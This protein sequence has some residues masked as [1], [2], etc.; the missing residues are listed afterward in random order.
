MWTS[1]MAL[2][3]YITIK[4]NGSYECASANVIYPVKS[5]TI[6]RKPRPV[7]NS[8]M[9]TARKPIMA[10]RPLSCSENSVKPGT[11]SGPSSK[12]DGRVSR[13]P[14]SPGMLRP[15]SPF[16]RSDD[17]ERLGADARETRLSPRKGR[18]ELNVDS[19]LVC[20][21]ERFGEARRAKEVDTNAKLDMMGT[22]NSRLPS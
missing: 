9:R 18:P 20:I 3:F 22:I 8:I 13:S 21:H 7:K 16:M 2:F 12:S 1:S 5:D 10:A 15:P 4:E 19:R 17:T 11:G 6:E 14:R